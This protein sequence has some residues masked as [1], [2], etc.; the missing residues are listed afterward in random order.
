M[1]RKPDLN[2][3]LLPRITCIVYPSLIM[4]FWLASIYI[5]NS[6]KEKQLKIFPRFMTLHQ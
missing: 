4:T 3:L 2:K 1:I 5:V 6:L